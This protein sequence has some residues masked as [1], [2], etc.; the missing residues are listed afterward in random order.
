MSRASDSRDSTWEKSGDY[1]RAR[2]IKRIRYM[3]L[4]FIP[5]RFPDSLMFLCHPVTKICDEGAF[6]THLT[7]DLTFGLYPTAIK[8]EKDSTCYYVH[9]SRILTGG[10]LGFSSVIRFPEVVIRT[11]KLNLFYAPI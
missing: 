2:L 8:A 3:W 7:F 11:T 1:S 5:Y 10:H 9:H 4:V 6:L